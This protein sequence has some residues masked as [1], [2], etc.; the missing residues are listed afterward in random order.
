MIKTTLNIGLVSPGWPIDDYPNGI[1][2]YVKTMN[3][4]LDYLSTSYVFS[5]G[6]MHQR[7]YP[8]NVIDVGAYNVEKSN[9]EK[10]KSKLCNKLL[11]KHFSYQATF[12]ESIKALNTAIIQSSFKLDLIEIEESFGLPLFAKQQIK[13]PVVCRLHGP[14]FIH[15]P[16][17]KMDNTPDYSLRTEYEGKGIRFADAITSP[18]QDV[19]DQVRE[20]YDI[21]LPQAEVIPNPVNAV[22]EDMQWQYDANAKPSILFVGRFDYHK[23]GDLML[24]AFK[25]IAQKDKDVELIFIGP[26]R[27]LMVNGNLISYEEY[28]QSVIKD[29][30]IKK[31]IQY[32]GHCNQTT[33]QHLRKSATITVFPSRYENFPVSLLESLS[34]GSPTIAS[35]V[36][37][38]K[39]IIQHTHS[40]ILV[41]NESPEQ[42]A[43]QAISLLNSPELMM[44]LSKNAIHETQKRY[45]PDVVAMQTL[46]FYKKMLA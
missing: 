40:G 22:N 19:L 7:V 38:I 42:I 10:L 18:S 25:L 3:E 9:F 13:I 5:L 44:T 39:E 26:D 37:G 23:G 14:W 31:R 16:I 4:A 28:L 32:L 11:G 27:G 2:S 6:N 8:S 30:A 46:N 24:Q 35:A 20:F 17:L 41:D 36:G 33:I 34:T 43:N 1:V 45:S 15:G 29:E 21:D 12:S